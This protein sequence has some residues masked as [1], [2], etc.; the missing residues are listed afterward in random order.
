MNA[1]IAKRARNLRRRNLPAVAIPP[2]SD[3][4]TS[5]APVA[6][7][8]IEVAPTGSIPATEIVPTGSKDT[9]REVKVVHA[10]GE[11]SKRKQ[12][13]KHRSKTRD[14]LKTPSSKAAEMEGEDSFE[15]F[16]ACCLERD[17]VLLA[18][19]AHTGVEEYLAHVLMQCSMFRHEKVVAEQKIRDVQQDF[20]H[21]QAKEKEAPKTKAAADARV[22]ELESKV[23]N[24]EAQL[25]ATI[26]KNRKKVAHVLESGRTEGFSTNLLAGKTEG[27]SKGRETFLQ[28]EEYQKSI[29]EAR[30]Q[31]ARDF[32]KAP[33]FKM[34]VDIQSSRYLNEGFDKC[35]SQIQ[36][37]KGFIEGLDQN[38]LDSPVMLHFSLT[39]RKM[40]TRS[41]VTMSFEALIAEVGDSPCISELNP[42]KLYSG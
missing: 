27:V 3:V 23:A 24:L 41:L 30:I 9:S 16:K 19:T 34:A 37:L 29:S 7:N 25:S 36:H 6:S 1:S 42:F 18:Q 26:E 8:P 4:E 12:K 17:Q 13:S 20:D 10:A 33:A 38:Q 28:Y 32:L 11:P 5:V 22:A 21:A 14:E 40:F 31:G 2:R 39:L 15:L 35:I